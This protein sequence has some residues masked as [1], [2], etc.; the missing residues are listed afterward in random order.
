ME[1]VKSIFFSKTIITNVVT[2]IASL[3]A[4]WGIDMTPDQQ[5]TTVSAIVL[6]GN[7]LS[8]LF[9]ATADKQLIVGGAQKVE[10]VN[11][12]RMAAMANRGTAGPLVGALLVC[13]LLVG[14]VS[15]GRT[16]TPQVTP[17]VTVQPTKVDTFIDNSATEIER[18]CTAIDLG[19]RLVSAYVTMQPERLN[20]IDQARSNFAAYCIEPP[21]NVPEALRFLADTYARI[22]AAQQTASARRSVAR[23]RAKGA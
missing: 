6:G 7:A 15:T 8:S 4:L 3:V 22:L 13:F 14:C 23:V 9:R 19:L 5:A 12:Q 1:L 10:Q 11:N 2:T 20:V 21:R 17:V 18:Y 16:I